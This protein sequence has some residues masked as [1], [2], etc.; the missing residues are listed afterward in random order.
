MKI[1]KKVIYLF[2]IFLFFTGC[3]GS[4]GPEVAVEAP[5]Y[6]FLRASA[7]IPKQSTM[8]QQRD[9]AFGNAKYALKS[10]VQTEVAQFLSTY[11]KSIGVTNEKTI[12][13][14]G[15]Y[16]NMDLSP[17]FDAVRQSDI[18]I[19]DSQAMQI[20]VRLEK[21]TFEQALKTAL[22]TNFRRDRSVWDRFQEQSSQD[23]LSRSLEILLAK[24]ND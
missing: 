16:V 19:V 1:S 3:G 21:G 2:L 20:S 7:T 13:R 24:G 12:S 6:D 14:L 8:R 22:T 11:L 15:E 9:L 18:A 4:K 5:D 10:Q 23:V 17:L